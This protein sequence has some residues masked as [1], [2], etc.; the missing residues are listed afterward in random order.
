MYKLYMGNKNYSSWSLRPWLLM[1]QLGIGFEEVMVSVVGRGA[2][3]MHRGYS[4]NGLVP[5]LH[6]NGFPVWD[7]LAIAEY[8]NDQHPDAHV[9]PQQAH[10][11]ARAR[12]VSAEM[13]SGFAALRNAMPMNV[14]F[15]LKGKQLDDAVAYDL[16]RIEQIWLDCRTEF[17]GDQPFLFGAFSAADAMFAPVVWRLFSYNAPVSEHSKTYMQTM[18]DLPAMREW[19]QDALS[20]TVK[21]HYDELSAEYGGSR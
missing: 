18:L 1:K 4:A 2:G 17:A 13:H 5:C 9:W 3:D 7:T 6:D 8:L 16:K 11:R 19:E 15:R 14:K 10:A 12:S 20:E 21:L